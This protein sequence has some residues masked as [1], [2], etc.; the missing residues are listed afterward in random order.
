MITVGDSTTAAPI[1]SASSNTVVALLP[2]TTP[3]GDASVTLMYRDQTTKAFPIR[4]VPVAFGIYTRNQAGSGPAVVMNEVPDSEAVAN[5]LFETAAP[6]QAVRISG[7]GLGAVDF[8]ETVVPEQPVDLATA[9]EVWVGVKAVTVL[10]SG[11]GN[12]SPGLDQIRIQLPDDVP[13]GCYVP[14][15]VRAGG[16]VSNFASMSISS[17]GKVCSDPTGLSSGDLETA[18]LNGRLRL[19]MISLA[20]SRYLGLGLEDES[21]A[22]FGTYSLESLT[23]VGAP[24]SRDQVAP[25][26]IPPY[27]SCA[28]YAGLATGNEFP[29][30]FREPVRP[31]G[32]NA[33]PGIDQNTPGGARPMSSPGDGVYSASRGGSLADRPEYLMPG[34]Y[35]ANNGNGGPGFGSFTAMTKLPD[36]LEWTNPTAVEAVSRTADVTMTW[37][38]ADRANEF[39]LIWGLSLDGAGRFA[40]FACTERLAA[41]QFTI[42][43]AVVSNMPESG[44]LEIGNG[45]TIPT[46]LIGV[47]AVSLPEAARFNATGLDAGCV[48]YRMSSAKTVPYQ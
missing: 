27:G 1:V 19:G 40:I 2:S 32:V 45:T 10:S 35:T 6:G 14:I 38:G 20:R 39:A 21:R 7:T 12:V 44:K 30:A 23:K 42:P 3:V 31:A 43:A 22:S 17:K 18:Q 26:G 8:D 15:A 4:V 34:D 5:S 13:E 37:N 24:F 41:G 33:G 28:V 36:V 16:V 46:G 29:P 11:R 47:S 9:V 48:M 25:L